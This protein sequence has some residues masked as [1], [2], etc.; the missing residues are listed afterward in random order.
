MSRVEHATEQQTSLKYGS[1]AYRRFVVGEC[2]LALKYDMAVRV[3]G[4][5]VSLRG[6][7]SNTGT[8]KK[9]LTLHVPRGRGGQIMRVGTK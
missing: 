9:H 3:D 7:L 5:A 8:R 6:S 1:I 2:G 4:A